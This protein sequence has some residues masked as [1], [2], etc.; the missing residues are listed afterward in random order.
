MR[1]E[2]YCTPEEHHN[3]QWQ[4]GR[5]APILCTRICLRNMLIIFLL[6]PVCTAEAAG[7][8]GRKNGYY[9]DDDV[10]EADDDG[11]STADDEHSIGRYVSMQ[12]FCAFLLR[13]WCA[14]VLSR[15]LAGVL[16]SASMPMFMVIFTT[17]FYAIVINSYVQLIYWYCQ[18]MKS[19][20]C[21]PR[22]RW[23][24][25]RRLS[26]EAEKTFRVSA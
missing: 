20:R 11:N 18:S 13:T 5:T 23:S 8:C 15:S 2:R 19:K 21:A 1:A 10:K 22:H 6:S 26:A 3:E 25:I 16:W 24:E 12:C 9:Y 4:C 7:Q 17:C 14:S